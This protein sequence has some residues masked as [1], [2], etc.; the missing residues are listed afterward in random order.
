MLFSKTIAPCLGARRIVCP[1][2]CESLRFHAAEPTS[3]SRSIALG[4]CPSEPPFD[5][6]TSDASSPAGFPDGTTSTDVGPRSLARSQV[7]TREPRPAPPSRVNGSSWSRS[8]P[9]H[10]LA[11]AAFFVR[12]GDP[13]RPLPQLRPF[14][15]AARERRARA[16]AVSPTHEAQRVPPILAHVG[17]R[18]F[19]GAAPRAAKSAP[20]P[21]PPPTGGSASPRRSLQPRSFVPSRTRAHATL[22]ISPDELSADTPRHRR[23]TSGD[24]SSPASPPPIQVSRPGAFPCR[25]SKEPEPLQA[26]QPANRPGD[27]SFTPGSARP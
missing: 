3:A 11:L 10:L 18:L 5:R 20:F 26:S 8:G 2:R 25:R 17:P 23:R 7:V 21:D 9:R 19:R 24:G 22:A 14:Q 16:S 15:D 1:T 27:V 6:R 12:I 4:H 13:I